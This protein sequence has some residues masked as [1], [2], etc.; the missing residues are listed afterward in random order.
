MNIK[1]EE[2]KQVIKTIGEE[3]EKIFEHPLY[4]SPDGEHLYNTYKDKIKVSIYSL[5]LVF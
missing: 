2:F 4:D 1:S 3:E 5:Y